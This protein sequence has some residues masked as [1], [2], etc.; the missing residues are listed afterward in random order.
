MDCAQFQKELVTKAGWN[1]WNTASV[2]SHVHMPDGFAINLGLKD[3]ATGRVLHEALIGRFGERDEKIHPGPRSDDGGYTQLTITFGEI[4]FDV[5]TAARGDEQYIIVTPKSQHRK[6][7]TLLVSCA[8]LWNMPGYTAAQGDALI[9]VMPSGERRVYAAGRRVR[10]MNTYLRNPYIALALDAPV[11]VATVPGL[12]VAQ[13]RALVDENKATHAGLAA[14]YQGELAEAYTAMK[15]CLAWDTIYEPE[16]Q[17]ICSPVSRLWNINWGGYVLFD[18]DSYFAALMF[19]LDNR[20]LAITNAIAITKEKTERGF[21]PNFGS[22]GDRKSR[23][24]SQPPVGSMVVREIYRRFGDRWLLEGLFDD[25]MEWNRWFKANRQLGDGTLCWGS[26][27]FES[28]ADSYFEL[29]HVGDLAGAALESGLDNSP[30][31]DD[32]GYDARTHLMMLSDVG[33]TGLYVMDCEAL[34]DIARVL[35]KDSEQAELLER[36]EATKRGI[37]CLWDEDF[38]F[39]LNRKTD[40]GELNRRISPTNFYALMSDR[41]TPEQARRCVDEHFYNPAE[42]WG[43]FIIPTI[44]RND[45]AYPDQEYW[46]GRIWAP[47]NYLCYLGLRRQKLADACRDMGQKS[48][49]LL[50][51]E[52]RLHGH[53]HENYNGDDG[54]GCDARS[55]DKFYHWGGL[56]GWIA[57]MEAG[58]VGDPWEALQG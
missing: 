53:V 52:W 37:A 56:S 39:F 47:T 1:T 17:Q 23:D 43:D 22:A 35:G 8:L 12:T 11:A 44:A 49:A 40:T 31:Y 34:A 16:K 19:S 10:E 41:V 46:R 7:P 29:Y 54:M 45:P 24:R 26:D 42:F 36:A 2:I 27:P 32:M 28:T 18:W 21:I 15:T 9:G 14:K 13:V 58:V 30:M 25:L 20:E 4:V 57:L 48:L 33:L 38:G 50:L 3:Q 5:E 51:K 55:S 6:A